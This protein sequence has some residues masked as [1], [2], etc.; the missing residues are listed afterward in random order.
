LNRKTID[1]SFPDDPFNVATAGGIGWIHGWISAGQK[2]V[3]SQSD[4]S[5]VACVIE[6]TF[7]NY[8]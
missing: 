4:R 1:Q 7:G 3:I 2:G 5:H 6:F 8:L